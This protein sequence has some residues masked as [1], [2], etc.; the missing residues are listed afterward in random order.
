MSRKS[1]RLT[2]TLLP[3]VLLWLAIILFVSC[4]REEAVESTAEEFVP[5]KHVVVIVG[6]D[7]A[8]S[9]LGAY[10]NSIIRTPNLDAL[11]RSGSMFTHAYVNSPICSASRQSMLTGKYPHATGVNL[12]FTP[13]D[14]SK[15]YTI[16]EH[17]Q[18]GDYHTAM[19]GKQHFN[20]WVWGELYADGYPDFGFDTLVDRND[21]NNWIRKNPPMEIPDSVVSFSENPE[22]LPEKIARMNPMV[23]PVPYRYEDASG[24]YLTNS[25]IQFIR[26]K[27]A[28]K[29]FLWLAY[30]EPHAPFEFPVEYSGKYK[31][32]G[33]ELPEGS[34]E[35][36][37]WV[38]ERFKGFTDQQKKGVIASYYSSVEYLDTNIGRVIQALEEEGILEETLIIYVGDHGY[39]L[40][41]HKRFEKHTMW[42]EAVKAPLIIAGGNRLPRGNVYDELI[43]FTDLAPLIAEATGQ[44]VMQEAQG[45]SFLSLLRGEPYESHEYVFSEYLEDNMAMVAN[46]KWKYIF[47]TGKRDL[48]LDYATGN[49]PAGITHLLYDL[50]NDPRETTN[51]AGRQP[52]MVDSLQ[53][54]MLRFFNETH[55]DAEDVPGELTRTGKLVWFCEPRDV[56]A[57]YGGVPLR[58]AQ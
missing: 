30:H 50:E 33:M 36:D 57:E 15:N 31:P 43:E 47:T 14:D 1:I 29:F 9:A 26:D 22:G 21:Y 51:L 27:S 42:E 10:G 38:P 18:N 55:P 6:D 24:T 4:N 5:F 56:G 12:L 25:A 28:D 45:K 49:G 39:L 17:M 32:D 7:H 40:N 58:V 19:I 44:P 52:E 41:D 23:R 11:A 20:T 13:F 16:A 46:H 3:P 48:G 8:T 35:D 54:V 53:R 34:P 2:K 37:R